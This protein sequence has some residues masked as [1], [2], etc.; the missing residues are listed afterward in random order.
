MMALSFMAQSNFLSGLLC[1]KSY[2]CI[3]LCRKSYVDDFGAHVN[4]YN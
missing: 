4:K 1:G 3:I 2:G